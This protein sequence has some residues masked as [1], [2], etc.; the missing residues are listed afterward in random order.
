MAHA[1]HSYSIAFPLARVDAA[2]GP[3]PLGHE[4]FALLRA[5]RFLPPLGH[6]R[7][8]GGYHAVINAELCA[9]Y[10]DDDDASYLYQ[11]LLPL[12]RYTASMAGSFAS[13][14]SV[15]RRLGRLAAKL[16]DLQ[17]A[18]RHYQ[19]AIED[20]RSQQA[21]PEL[22]LTLLD[23]AHALQRE[24]QSRRARLQLQAAEQQAAAIGMRLPRAARSR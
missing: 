20:N 4:C 9:V 21:W 3:T 7:L 2:T 23:S 24:G 22:A 17:T 19:L 18:Q 14:G 11:L 6:M 8:A 15:A 5:G 12:E 13:T 1:A 10:G 16:G